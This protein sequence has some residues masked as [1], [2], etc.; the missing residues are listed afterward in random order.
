MAC[1]KRF[2]HVHCFIAKAGTQVSSKAGFAL[3]G[4]LTFLG[5]D[6]GK[7]LEAEFRKAAKAE[8]GLS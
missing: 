2:D 3:Q 8:K 4:S 7:P 5:T 6:S 1:Q